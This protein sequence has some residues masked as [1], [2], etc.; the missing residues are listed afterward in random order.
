[1]HSLTICLLDAHDLEQSVKDSINLFLIMSIIMQAFGSWA[2]W[3]S[4]NNITL[5]TLKI[6]ENWQVH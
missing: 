6:I 3:I 4:Q 5:L 2:S 1:M